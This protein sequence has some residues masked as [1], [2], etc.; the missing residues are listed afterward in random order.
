MRSL[1]CCVPVAALALACASTPRPVSGA[2]ASRT[3]RSE[4]LPAAAAA[5]PSAL[6]TRTDAVEPATPPAPVAATPATSP[7]DASATPPARSSSLGAEGARVERAAYSFPIP[8]GWKEIRH[9][10][11][12]ELNAAG[13]AI[14]SRPAGKE[15]WFTPSVVIAPVPPGALP[16]RDLADCRAIAEAVAQLTRT[17]VERADFL[18]LPSTGKSCQFD[19]TSSMDA[20]RRGRG[21]VLVGESPWTMTCNYD[22]RDAEAL[23]ACDAAVQGFRFTGTVT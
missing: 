16:T 8:A 13:G 10:S 1:W 21:T 4:D 7:V 18:T 20:N 5:Q 6:A 9:P 23:P 12:A 15:G 14:I 17:R 19:L 22:A 3:S 11:V 2:T